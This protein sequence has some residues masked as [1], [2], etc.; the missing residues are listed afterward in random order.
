MVQVMHTSCFCGIWTTIERF[1]ERRSKTISI[2][3]MSYVTD[4]MMKSKIN[5]QDK[6]ELMLGQST[7]GQSPA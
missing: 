1:S 5:H 4:D 6:V 3:A 7:D 2:S